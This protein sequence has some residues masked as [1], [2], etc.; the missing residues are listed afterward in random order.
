MEPSEL[1][2]L[3]STLE[4]HANEASHGHRK[5]GE[6]WAETKEINISFKGTR[7]PS[8]DDRQTAWDRFQEIVSGVK[9]K[10]DEQRDQRERTASKSSEL[11]NQIIRQAE[12]A[13]PPGALADLI[14]DLVIGPF[15]LLAEAYVDIV[16]LGAMRTE[17]DEKKEELKYYSHQLR[18]AWNLFNDSKDAMLGRDKH[19]CFEL[20]RQVQ[21]QLDAEWTAWKSWNEQYHEAKRGA[22]RERIENSIEKLESRVSNLYEI[23][24]KREAHLSELEDKRD[25]AW[26]DD[27]RDRV[28]GWIDEE[29]DRIR[30]IREQIQ[31]VEGWLDEQ[32]GRL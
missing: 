14:S 2:K 8:K 28:E 3:I 19:E 1:D 4:K 27:F 29:E 21:E 10:Q 9:E 18:E 32:R 17:I 5:W 16:T 20:I 15:K 24:S 6:V 23:L 12:K 25:T 31:Q 26:N 30:S 13:R 22:R 7:Y 11:K